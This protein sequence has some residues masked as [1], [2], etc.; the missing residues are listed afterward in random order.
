MDY[1][2]RVVA[3]LLALALTL[4]LA[5]CGSSN[6]GNNA[7]NQAGDNQTTNGGEHADNIVC[8]LIAEPDKLDPQETTNHRSRQ[9]DVNLY[10]SLLKENNDG[11]L[12]G[13]LAETW[14]VS[15]DQLTYTFHLR[16]GVLFHNGETLKASDVVF[17]FN[18]GMESPYV[19]QFFPNVTAVNA[20]DEATVEVTLSSPVSFF[21]K[22]MTLP[23][24]AIVSEKA[25]TEAGED[26]G[27]N[28]VG[29]GPYKFVSWTSGSSIK[30]TAFEDYWGG[31][32]S[33]TDCEYRIVTDMTT[34]TISLEKGEIDFF[35]ELAATSKQICEENAQL[36]YEEGASTS[37]EHILINNENEKMADLNLRKALA[38]A[39]DKE[40]IIT[41]ATSGSGIIADSQVAPTM[42]LYC[43]DVKGYEYD[44]E[45]A[46]EYLA[47]SAYPDGVTLTIQVNSGYREKI[48][49]I[50]KA[51]YA[52]IGVELKIETLEFN[53]VV[54]NVTA[55]DFELAL[56]G[57]NLHLTNPVLAIDNNFNSK[58][59]GGGGNYQRYKNPEVDQLLEAMYA[60]TDATKQQE[61]MKQV[62][63]ALH[64]DVANIPL[65]WSPWSIAY[66]NSLQNVTYKANSYYT[67]Y[68]FSW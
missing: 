41:V 61:M 62:L 60:E 28:P 2:K 18:R 11:S 56:L 21:E 53:T 8:A 4:A 17:T 5:A 45:K 46:K 48:A 52:E 9:V 19:K 51:N 23:Q 39:T 59:S 54:A 55:G 26:F 34:G 27:R 37:Y 44:I 32:A 31:K 43:A 3:L 30:L 40:S 16:Q 10:E 38:Y 68:D 20:V 47:Q 63:T 66:N 25:V 29:T 1:K 6:S 36:T 12:S 15:E 33:I 49:Q 14:E 57:R 7:G 13:C 35:Y 64:D 50:L 67:M 42:D 58:Y 22:L 65:Y 24:T